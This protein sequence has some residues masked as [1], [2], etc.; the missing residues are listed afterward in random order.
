MKDLKLNL[1][2]SVVL[3]SGANR[4]IGNAIALELLARGAKKVYAGTRD[5]GAI[6]ATESSY[7]GKLVP[8]QLDVTDEASINNAAKLATDVDILINNAGVLLGDSLLNSDSLN[9][10]KIHFDVN[11][12]G[13]MKLTQAFLPSIRSKAKGAIVSIS[14]LAGL[15]NMPV[16]GSYSVSKA[17]VHSIIQGL[18]GDLTNESVAVIGVYPGPIDTEMA[19]GFEMDKDSPQAVAKSIADG[20]ENGVEDV[21][22]DQMSLQVEPLYMG[23]PKAV[24]TEFG[25]YVA[26]VNQD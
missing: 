23:N 15:G 4:G 21:F 25:M 13:L 12:I 26:P 11:V 19:K 14:S 9:N 8:L 1:K 17:A 16:I 6:D 18:R 5:L 2:D 3:I 20:I 22:P 10:L 7:E 24:E